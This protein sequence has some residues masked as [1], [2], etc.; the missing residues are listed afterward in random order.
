MAKKENT[1][2]VEKTVKET[3]EVTKNN[4]E[5]VM[6]QNIIISLLV[7]ACLLMIIIL[8]VVI[9]GH[10]AKLKDGKEIIASIDGKDITSEELFDALKKQ[11][12]TNALI[13]TIDD[14]IVNK[15]IEDTDAAKKYAE[16][17]I[18]TLKQQYESIGYDFSTVL[19]SNGYENED[20]LKT[21]IISDYKKNK[22]VEKYLS[23]NLTDDEI[24]AY[25][26]KEI[27]G[28]ISSKHILIQPDTTNATTEEEK[29]T[30]EEAAKTKAQEVIQKLNDGAAWSDLVKEY[31]ADTASV[32]DDGL[33]EF[34]KGDVVDE[35]YQAS[36][37]L[38]D[39][40]Y[41]KEPV[42]STYGYHIILKVSEAEKP[43]LEDSLETIKS[44]LVSNMLSKDENLANKTWVDIRKKYNLEINDTKLEKVYNSI[45][46]DL[47]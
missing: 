1:K 17:Q 11:N 44:D 3:K 31:S 36:I 10:E 13:N 42:K 38:N 6:K 37:T 46:S 2:K 24:N 19:A 18:A 40:E 41:T 20:Q 12:G 43:S 26:D 30:A 14:F 21:D 47:K 5:E 9:K 28:K 23:D 39:N 8:M 34:E 32:A 25:Y 7:I 15:E 29:T 22:V 45:I 4:K 16:A 27:H 35:F 33:I